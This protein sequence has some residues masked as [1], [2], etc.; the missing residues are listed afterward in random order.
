MQEDQN[1]VAIYKKMQNQLFYMIPEK[2]DRIYL[3]ASVIQRFGN[4]ETGEMFFYYFPK[5]I[6]KKNP[7]NSYEIPTRFNLE[8][9][10]YFELTSKLYELIKQLKLEFIRQHRKPWTSLTI[11]VE[12]LKFI[13]EFYYDELPIVEEEVEARHILWAYINLNIPMESLNKSQ[14]NLLNNELN[15][16]K[17]I[18]QNKTTYSENIYLN[19]IKNIVRYN[20]EKLEYVSDKIEEKLEIKT[21]I[22]NKRGV[23]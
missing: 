11:K 17:D 9:K 1:I 23:I 20:K 16:I 22:L 21:Q 7:V 13:V 14:R 2:W 6:L 8:E 12:G 4:F 10:E 19:P 3:Y 18:T 5:G 15:K